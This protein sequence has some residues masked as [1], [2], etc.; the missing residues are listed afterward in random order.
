MVK[1]IEGVGLF[2]TCSEEKWLKGRAIVEELYK[3]VV[4]DEITTLSFKKLEKGVGFLVYLSCT[5]PVKFPY[6]HR[7]YNTM[8][9]WQEGW[10]EEGWKM[11]KKEWQSFLEEEMETEGDWRE[12][13]N[14]QCI[15][16]EPKKTGSSKRK[17]GQD[18]RDI[19][20]I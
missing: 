18:S 1:S 10:N 17:R 5:F 16:R 8:N 13:L 2:V 14:G 11:T 3:M 20:H 7:I 9:G 19:S 12:A 6:L 15:A 4:I